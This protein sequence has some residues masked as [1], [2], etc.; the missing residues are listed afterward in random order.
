M[1]FEALGTFKQ[2]SP[3]QRK[4]RK[5]KH[6]RFPTLSKEPNRIH[7]R[8]FNYYQQAHDLL[9]GALDV[10]LGVLVVEL[11]KVHFGLLPPQR[12][13]IQEAVS[14]KQE[15]QPSCIGGV[16]MEYFIGLLE[17]DT[18]AWTLTLCRG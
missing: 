10:L 11:P 7:P 5:F 16:G 9:G 8:I 6:S 15:V 2:A 1:K 14:W 13:E 3:I 17:K 12:G 18:H 4:E